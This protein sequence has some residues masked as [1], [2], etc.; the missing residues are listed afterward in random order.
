ME[1]LGVLIVINILL[2][3]IF[4]LYKNYNVDTFQAIVFNYLTCVTV[5][6]F[7]LGRFPITIESVDKPWFPYSMLLGLLFIIG[8][9]LLGITVKVFGVTITSIAQKMALIMSVTFTILFFNEEFNLLKGLG[10]LSAIA[11]IIL[12]N[13]PRKGVDIE[14]KRANSLWYL[15]FLTFFISGLIEILLFYVE[16][17]DIS[18]N[19]DIG[20]VVGLF[21]MAGILGGIFMIIG[22]I[23]K[24]LKFSWKNVIGGIALGVP[25]FF[26]I[27]LL[28]KL[29]NTGLDGSII[30]PILNVSIILGSAILGLTL[31]KEKLSKLQW[32]GFL[33]GVIC[34]TLI[35]L[36]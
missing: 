30:F 8:F 14:S 6:S 17:K 4:R 12:I 1:L 33:L 27:Y 2:L 28:L 21:G 9:N 3:V 20:F 25:N 10:I 34:I 29:I 18:S 11:S 13:I 7:V 19:A 36:S 32:I 26:T 23:T 5:G 22:L 16:A 15:I 24:K 35:S 31:F